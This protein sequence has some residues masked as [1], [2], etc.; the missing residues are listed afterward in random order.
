MATGNVYV[1]LPIPKMSIFGLF[2]D[3]G[4]FHNGTALNSAVNAGIAM[5]LGKVFGLYFPLYMS[6]E[7]KASYGNSSYSEK[8]RFTLKMNIVNKGI[9]LSSLFN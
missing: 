7:L 3:L 2:A 4:A 9:K 8:I 6:T 5:R 1:Q